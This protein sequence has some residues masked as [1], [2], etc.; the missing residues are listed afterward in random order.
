MPWMSAMNHCGR[1]L[2]V[3]EK[4]TKIK[5]TDIYLGSSSSTQYYITLSSSI[6]WNNLFLPIF[7]IWVS[8]DVHLFIIYYVLKR[9]RGNIGYP[10]PRHTVR[11]KVPALL[12]CTLGRENNLLTPGKRKIQHQKST[13]A[14]DG[15]SSK[16][17]YCGTVLF[18][19]IYYNIQMT[20]LW[21][22][23]FNSKESI[24]WRNNVCFY[25]FFETINPQFGGINQI[26]GRLFSLCGRSWTKSHFLIQIQ[27]TPANS[28][29]TQA[30]TKVNFPWISFIHLL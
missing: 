5:V 22:T 16:N 8:V 17:P 15:L 28:N 25:P 6:L 20:E 30:R 12:T 4:L 21:L 24:A 19:V 27:M 23:E 2:S 9:N 14:D 3:D 18:Q 10:V 29:L 1:P 26:S 7:N 11:Q 13:S